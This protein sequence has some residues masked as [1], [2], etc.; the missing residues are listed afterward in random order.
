MSDY[1]IMLTH[2]CASAACCLDLRPIKI[3]SCGRI[4]LSNFVQ[5]LWTH[6]YDDL[7]SF[8]HF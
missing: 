8:S 1:I 2:A 3:I 7:D 4:L 6:E 5:L